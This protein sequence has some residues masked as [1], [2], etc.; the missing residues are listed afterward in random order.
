MSEIKVS[1]I[2]NR[3][4]TGKPNFS[5]HPTVD[6]SVDPAAPPTR[7]EGSTRPSS[8]REGDTWY[9]TTNANFEVYLNSKWEVILGSGYKTTF[10]FGDRGLV[11][12]N[13]TWQY[14][15]ITTAGNASAWG[16]SFGVTNK[17]YSCAASDHTYCVVA[18]G[19]GWVDSTERYTIATSGSAAATWSTLTEK[20]RYSAASS[21]KQVMHIGGGQRNSNPDNHTDFLSFTTSGTATQGG[22]L[23]NSRTRLAALSD[24]I[25]GYYVAGQ[26]S[27]SSGYTSYMDVLNIG[28][29]AIAVTMSGSRTVT[30]GQ[31][32]AAGGNTWRGLMVGGFSPAQ[33]TIDY[34]A[35]GISGHATD[36][37]DMLSTG[38]GRAATAND[39]RLIIAGG[40]TNTT[41]N[42]MEFVTIATKGNAIDFGD[43]ATADRYLS[44][45]S[46]GAS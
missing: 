41:T 34:I 30:Q 31:S 20:C 35:L 5:V 27:S 18:G 10:W 1:S 22:N 8:P 21:N 14:Y 37:G 17:Q 2:T 36:F 32:V 28:T 7:H 44:Y 11:H 43:L 26:T 33:N 25:H 42:V 4:G 19:S 15:D 39:T 6:G 29:T 16:A 24:G 9:D 46:G 13:N 3:A 45:A 12:G 38:Y 40:Y 23:S